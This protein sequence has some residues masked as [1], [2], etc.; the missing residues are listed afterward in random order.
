M[1]CGDSRECPDDYI[2]KY[3]TSTPFSE[4]Q[5]KKIYRRFLDLDMDGKGYLSTDDF[6]LITELALNPLVM[7]V[8]TVF[9]EKEEDAIE[10]DTFIRMLAVFHPKTSREEKLNFIFKIYDVSGDG[11]LDEDEISQVLKM[12]VG[13]RLSNKQLRRICQRVL[14]END[15]NGDGRITREEFIEALEVVEHV[16]VPL[17]IKF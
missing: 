5:V 15:K 16:D 10:F 17:S 11:L 2:E 6:L 13:N 1:G 9:D 3:S 4:G 12:L 8:I 7:R 14:Q